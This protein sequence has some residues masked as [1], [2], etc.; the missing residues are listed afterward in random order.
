MQPK[1]WMIGFVSLAGLAISF[2]AADRAAAQ[3]QPPAPAQAPA[4]AQPSA[5]AQAPERPERPGFLV[6]RPGAPAGTAAPP[7][8]M[9]TLLRCKGPI[10]SVFDLAYEGLKT[11]TAVFG[12]NPGG[13]EGGQFDKTPVLTTT[14]G[15]AKGTC[16]NAHLSAQVG[17]KQSYGVSRATMF[18]VSLTRLPSGPTRHMIGHYEL[19]YGI[20]SPGI[21]AEPERDVETLSANFFQ[22]VGSGPH[23]VQP[24]NYRLDV[25][26][27]GAP[28]FEGPGGAIGAAF[29][30]KLYM[31]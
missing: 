1:I 8:P 16:L 26:W 6:P 23:D 30:L 3:A 25:F 19:P 5:Q 20:A 17:A 14:V 21:W 11:T 27:A 29:V 12:A 7:A 4:Q 31:Q 18:Q 10:S 2:L 13:G 24:G 22:T 28:W 9:P 15:L